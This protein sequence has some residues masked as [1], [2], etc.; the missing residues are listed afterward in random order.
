MK[1]K[2]FLALKAAIVEGTGKTSISDRTLNAYAERLSTQITE[3]SQIA[4]AIK[5]DIIVLKEIAGN[6]SAVAAEAV[7]TVKLPEKAV[8]KTIE[9]TIEGE[10]EWFKSYREK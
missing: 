5:P 8:D 7:K 6:I 1:E 9:K 2:I 3:E 10:P 4:E